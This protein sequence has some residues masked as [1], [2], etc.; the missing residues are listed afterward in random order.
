MRGANRYG[1][2]P[3]MADISPW[4]DVLAAV[5]AVLQRIAEK[6]AQMV[7]VSAAGAVRLMHPQVGATTDAAERHPTWCAGQ[8][9]VRATADEV[10]EA[11][12]HAYNKSLRVL[13]TP[14][15]E[16]P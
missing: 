12:V 9:D 10:R 2:P 5:D 3:P 1:L 14:W 8:F 6:G 16:T 7:F 11:M 4:G 13:Q 15:G